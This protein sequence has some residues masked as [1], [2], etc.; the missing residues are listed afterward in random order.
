LRARALRRAELLE[1]EP[2]ASP[3]AGAGWG[4][5]G[6]LDDSPGGELG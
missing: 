4:C 6:A 3:A 1:R 5:E 2:E